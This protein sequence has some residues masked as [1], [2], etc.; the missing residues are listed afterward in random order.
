MVGEEPV[1]RIH[2]EAVLEIEQFRFFQ[3]SVIE[4]FVRPFDLTRAPLL[5]VGLIKKE[6]TTY[7]LMVDMHHIVT[8][9]TSQEIFT[10]EFMAFYADK[11]GKLPSL[12]LQYKDFACWQNSDIQSCGNLQEKFPSSICPRIIQ[13]RWSGVLPGEPFRLQ[14]GKGRPVH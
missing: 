3:E 11:G 8:D 13:D 10:R 4:D 6:E 12:R 1:Q 7:I 9:G 2:D 14:S 5:R